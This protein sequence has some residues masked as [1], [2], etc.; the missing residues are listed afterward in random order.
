MDRLVEHVV[1]WHNSHPLAKK[2]TIYD[3]H[4]MGVVALPFL[5]SGGSHGGGAPVEPMLDNGHGMPAMGAVALG[6]STLDAHAANTTAEH[7]DALAD[8]EEPPARALAKLT[9]QQRL[10]VLASAAFWRRGQPRKSGKSSSGSWPA[11]SERFIS[12]SVRRVADFAQR[13]GF[14]NPPGDASWPQRVVP[15]DEKLLGKHS[16]AWPY[17]IYLLTAAIDAGTSRTRVLIGMG[18]QPKIIGPRCW[19]PLRLGLATLVLVGLLAMGLALRLSLGKTAETPASAPT[20]AAS[21]AS[22]SDV[23]SASSNAA[24]GRVTEAEPASAASQT[25]ADAVE[26]AASGSPTAS[27]TPGAMASGAASSAASGAESGASAAATPASAPPPDI[28]PQLVTPIPK[29]MPFS[30]PKADEAEAGSKALKTG[31]TEKT[32]KPDEKSAAGKT[33]EKDAGTS[34]GKPQEAR[35][36]DGK[37]SASAKHGEEPPAA[38]L[39]EKLGPLGKA[40]DRTIH[41]VLKPDAKQEAKTVVALVGPVVSSQVDAQAA[42]TRLL[43]LI[44]PLHPGA[45]HTSVV[46]T[47]DGW[48]PAVWPFDNR[49]EAQLIN[50]TLVARGL[51]TKAVD[52]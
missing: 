27:L 35:P 13:Q 24:S 12:I 45:L 37:T 18:R 47:P 46:Q 44:A 1:A 36:V 38:A 28:R 22:G 7:L 21:A 19:S 26:P 40:E 50:A 6:E 48:R 2:I 42:A 9:W 49:Q 32:D 30:S 33:A 11:Y 4:T 14:L 8:Q 41:S 15:I 29:R 43:G 34:T 5:R 3:V 20:A 17:E 10:S 25:G 52:F 39:V 31:K 51:K 16:G 23:A